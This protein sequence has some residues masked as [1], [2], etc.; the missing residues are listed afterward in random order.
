MIVTRLDRYF[1]AIA[2]PF[3]LSCL[4]ASAYL[5]GGAVRDGLL[6]RTKDVFD[7][8]LVL[9]A[10][11]IETAR[12]IA[13]RYQG[14]F[15]ILDEAR[16]IAR[17]VFSNGTL[18]FAL[19]EGDSLTADL[20]RRDFTINAIAY[21]FQTR[22]LVDPF[23]GIQ[24]LEQGKIEMISPGNLVNDPLRLL[25]AYRQAA[26]LDFSIE[27]NTRKTIRSLGSLL[28]RVAA[29][30]VQTEFNYLLKSD[31]GNKWLEALWKDGLIQLYFPTVDAVKIQQLMAVETA[32]NR[33]KFAWNTFTERCHNWKCL[34][35]IATLVASTPE[36]AEA[37]LI[38]LKYSRAEVKAV[39]KTVE[40]LP[41][42]Q[43]ISSLPSLRE[44][45]FFFL[46]TRDVFPILVA[47][48]IALGISPEITTPLIDRYLNLQD[49]VAYPQ[50]IVT[51]NH[52]ITKLNL[53]PSPLIGKLLTEIQIACLE[54]KISTPQE[55]LQYA[56]NFLE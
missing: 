26:Q 9:P 19:Q 37:E 54:G 46:Q 15:V 29:E 34:T 16:Q 55:A 40:H 39:V 48:A 35:K 49:P 30:R 27:A 11:P 45:Y 5:V 23:G 21:N 20:Q 12:E 44:Q 36:A 24:A 42:L 51:G 6:N 13:R 8:D 52:L 22:Q 2:L 3:D 18:D 14:G 7:L 43:A 47:R 17:V 53:K 28:P 4:P 38:N 31:T 56:A 25:R 50:A 33:L 1:S 32:V 10:K 41:Q